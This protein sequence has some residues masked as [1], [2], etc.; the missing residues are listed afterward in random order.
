[1]IKPYIEICKAFFL[2]LFG[3]WLFIPYI[4]G[5]DNTA[6]KV[7]VKKWRVE[8]RDNWMSFPD[9]IQDMT[10]DYLK[11]LI[12]ELTQFKNQMSVLKELEKREELS[13]EEIDLIMENCNG[14]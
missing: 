5:M 2:K 8:P 11:L 3:Y 13:E 14:I 6:N 1:M 9:K 12:T 10:T 4:W 7:S